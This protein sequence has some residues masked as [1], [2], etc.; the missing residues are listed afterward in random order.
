MSFNK[1]ISYPSLLLSLAILGSS[2]AV[3][4]KAHIDK[5]AI[6]FAWTFFLTGVSAVLM[7]FL[8]HSTKRQHETDTKY[9]HL[10]NA[11]NRLLEGVYDE[12]DK[13]EKR[14]ISSFV[15]LIETSPEEY[16]HFLKNGIKKEASRRMLLKHFRKLLTEKELNLHQDLGSVDADQ[17]LTT[18]LSSRTLSKVVEDIRRLEKA[19]DYCSTV[20]SP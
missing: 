11:F 14:L 16:Q 19:I 10:E 9:L 13:V 2:C 20:T 17:P 12:D 15:H 3:L 18:L 8:Y 7:I 4:W 6:P 1:T 5:L